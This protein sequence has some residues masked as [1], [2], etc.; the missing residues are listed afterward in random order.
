MRKWK[1]YISAATAAALVLTSLPVTDAVTVKADETMDSLTVDETVVVQPSIASKFNDTDGDGFGEF[2]G[3]GT[4]LCWW[5]NRLGYSEKMTSQAAEV[6]FGDTGLDMNIGRYNVGGGDYV[7][8]ANEKAVVY[9]LETEGKKPTYKGTSMSVSTN[10]AFKDTVY[11]MSD[12]D[13]GITKGS[14]VGEIKQIGYVKDLDGAVGNGDNLKYTVNVEETGK[15]TV[16]ILLT[17]NSDTVRNVAIR[18]NAEAEK[19]YVVDNATLKKNQ[20]TSASGSASALFLATIED[21]SLNAGENT[22]EVGGKGGWTLDYIKMLVVKSSDAGVLPQEEFLHF[23]HIQRSDSIVPG[24]AT[25]V[26]K[27]DTTKKSIEEYENEYARVDEECGYAWNYDWDAD[28]NQMN[29]LKAAATASGEEFI[30]E[31]FSN[32]PP[33]F[34]TYSGCSSGAVDAD[35]DNLRAN[36]YHA[37][38]TY[39]ADVI[40]HWAEEEVIDFQ[41]ATPMNEPDTSYWGAFSNKQ[42][43]CHFSPGDSQSDIIVEFKKAIDENLENT[44]SE[45]AKKVLGRLIFSASDE[46]DIDKQITNYGKLSDEAKE[47]VTRIDTHTYSGSNR[48]GLCKTAEEAG[49]NLWM[50]E[51]DGA[52]NIG[53]NAGEMGAALGLAERIITDLNGLKSSAWILWNAVDMHVDAN[54]ETDGG[55]DA[56]TFEELYKSKDDGGKGVDL[57]S[58]Y[59]GIAIGDHNKKEVVLTKKYYGYGQFTRYIRPGA[60]VIGSNNSNTLVTF[61]PDKK[62]AVVVAINTSADDE[63]WKFD[64]GSFSKMGTTVKAV[65]SSGSLESGENWADVTNKASIIV[66]TGKKAFAATIKANSITTFIIEDVE[67]DAAQDIYAN[68]T[69]VALKDDMVTGSKP[70]NDDQTNGVKNVYDGKTNTFFDGLESGYVQIDLGKISRIGALGY[71]SRTSYT[72]R[73]KGT[74]YGSND[75]KNWTAIYTIKNA[76]TAGSVVTKY[77]VDFDGSSDCYRYIKYQTSDTVCCNIAEIE[78]HTLD[79]DLASLISLYEARVE[80]RTFED[81]TAFEAAI[82]SAKEV[83]ADETATEEAK[84]N[85]MK[86]IVAAYDALKEL[87]VK[88]YTSFT[89]VKGG[90]MYDTDGERIQAHGGQIQKIVE[91]YDYNENGTID[92]DEHEFWF[93]VGEDKT[94]DYRPCPGIK[95]Y[96][97]KDLYNWKDMGNILRTA[98]DWEQF[99]TD[100]YFTSLYDSEGVKPGDE[101]YD[102]LFTVYGDIWAP[103]DS[104]SGCVIERPKMLY[105]EKN[106]NYV[107]WFHADGQT[108]GG[109]GSNYSKAKAGVAVSD[110]P[111]GPFKLLGS[112]RLNYDENADHGFDNDTSD[113]LGGGGH[114]RDMNLFKDDDKTAYVLYSS[115]GNE[116]MHIAQLNEDY[117]G[118]KEPNINND[119]ENPYFSRNFIGESREAPAMFKY[120]NKYYMITSGC[121]GWSPN[122]AKYAVADKPLGPWTMMGDPCVDT[123]AETTYNTQSTCVIPVDPANGKFIYMGDRWYNEES[124]VGGILRDSRYIWLPIEFAPGDQIVL[125]RY[126]DWTLDELE[127]KGTYQIV[128]EIP[129]L[130]TSV[131]DLQSKLP[132]TITVRHD[133]GETEEMAMVW[134]DYPTVDRTMGTVSVTGTSSD[135]TSYK[136]K[137]SFVDENT[138]YFFDSAAKESEYLENVKSVAGTKLRNT[139]PDQQYTPSNRA[140]YSSVVGTDIGA[141]NVTSDEWTSGYYAM[142]DKTIEYTFALEAGEYTVATGYQE[143]WN[144]E[145]G[146]KLAAIADEKELASTTFTLAKTDT[147]LQQNISFTLDKAANV[148]IVISETV[149]ADPVLSWIAVMQD[150]KNGELIDITAINKVVA[151]A[152]ALN[153]YEYTSESWKAFRK[154]Y[155]DVAKVHANL[156]ATEEQLAKAADD[157][158]VAMQGMVTTKAQLEKE[159]LANSAEKEQSAYTEATWKVYV[160]ALEAA[161]A[162]FVKE[163]VTEEEIADVIATLKTAKRALIVKKPA[164]STVTGT[165]SAPETPSVPDGSASVPTTK[166]EPVI[167][168][169]DEYEVAFGSKAF[170]LEAEVAAGTGTLTYSSSDEKVAVVAADGT[171]TLKGVGVCTITISLAESADY[172]AISVPVTLTVNPKTVKVNSA[173]AVKGKKLTVKWKKDNSVTGYEVQIALNKTFKSG[174]KTVNIKKAKTSSTT[175]KK[176]KK[177]KKYYVHVRA[178]KNVTVEG[179]S[180]KLYGEWSKVKTSNKIK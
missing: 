27:I 30:A 50:S 122:P 172:T 42:E 154:V 180:V 73:C 127:G 146:T 118:V 43:G 114:V 57:E 49:E 141:K 62:Q 55:F 157:L 177:G 89:G 134:S 24:Y 156:S 9:D 11:T 61:D 85:A 151:K 100:E 129:T 63:T 87:F 12:A 69:K 75:G 29:I 173:K 112:Y 176:L 22:I 37:F 113:P 142:G 10:T 131:E 76:P 68:M 28:A 59:W 79:V 174:K 16:K 8:E 32:S 38:A 124:P 35:S 84:A 116:T 109:T 145:R 111:F 164:S 77:A 53:T 139:L 4:S 82:A 160:N 23:A 101:N 140:G 88:N 47:I 95:G 119:E 92:D 52:Y 153:E 67:Y 46:T 51:V 56:D 132:A 83:N 117:T 26:T 168:C 99:T 165:P 169:D 7:V 121:T 20:I 93:W 70:W 133:S 178:Y 60:A 175:F 1:Q 5:A 64:M 3:W 6:F 31:A 171:V 90:E 2:E 96:I 81:T 39:M 97:S 150:E 41:S 25:N 72:D 137:I 167:L 179:K 86:S 149:S 58:G 102:A 143:W 115:D 159:I 48:S 66:D 161:K 104:G 18:V 54:A 123:G 78:I 71:A 136:Q 166:S 163:I 152:D 110:S 13:F 33:Y 19:D 107:I 14:K 108:P 158:N 170:N 45:N 74:F 94:N 40:T 106:D 130:A 144:T 98:T 44:T 103:N 128:T 15:Y 34:M 126:S 65:R 36:S 105:N 125:R 120:H 91:D 135:N 155:E 80:S 21:V 138:I 148:T 17:H 147:A 162:L